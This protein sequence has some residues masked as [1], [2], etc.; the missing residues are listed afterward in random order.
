MNIGDVEDLA[1]RFGH[2]ESQEARFPW[3]ELGAEQTG[4]AHIRVK[5]GR[6]QPFAHLHHRAEEIYVVLSGS[7][8]LT[9]DGETVPLAPMDAVRIGPGAT[10]GMEAGPDGLEILAFGPHVEGDAEILPGWPGPEGEAG[11]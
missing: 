1:P 9:V 5:P 3:R 7:G 10:R 2:G 11:G 8:T 4:F 6:R